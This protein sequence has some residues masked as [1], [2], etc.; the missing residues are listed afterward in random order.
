M[1]KDKLKELAKRIC[2]NRPLIYDEYG[3]GARILDADSQIIA[4]FECHLDAE[5][6]MDLI[7]IILND[8]NKD[9]KD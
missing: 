6:F 2:N 9:A 8:E 5:A 4:D 3:A 1:D 7:E